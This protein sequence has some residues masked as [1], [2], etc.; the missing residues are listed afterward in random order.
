MTITSSMLGLCVPP[1]VASTSIGSFADVTLL[2]SRDGPSSVA[3]SR[4]TM[5][6]QHLDRLL[7]AYEAKNLYYL[8]HPVVVVE[9]PEISSLVDA[10]ETLFAQIGD[11]PERARACAF[12]ECTEEQLVAAAMESEVTPIP[13]DPQD[14][15][16]E[17]LQ[18][19][20]R[21]LKAHAVVLRHAQTHMLRVAHGHLHHLDGTDA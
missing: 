11:E 4:G 16:G 12:R 18:Y 3:L 20:I 5:A 21:Y 8:R 6:A 19:V 9:P 15:D 17:S 13:E 14:E 10:L 2:Y 1:E 7:A